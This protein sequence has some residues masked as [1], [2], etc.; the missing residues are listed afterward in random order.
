[1]TT[2]Y[3]AFID[4]NQEGPFELQELVT[5]GVRPST[6]VWCKGMDDWKRADEVEE[7]RS[8]FKRHLEVRKEPAPQVKEPVAAQQEEPA[9]QTPESGNPPEFRFG[10]IPASVEPEPD[11]N[12][13]PRVSMPLAVIAL[14]FFC[15]PTGIAAVIFTYKAQKK[16]DEAMRQGSAELLKKE[17]HE[18]AR[19]AKMWLGLSVAFGIILWTLFFSIV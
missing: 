14:L 4:G 5:A 3:F 13:P 2:K 7:I 11:Y 9:S 19:L 15:L 6:Y 16:W 8:L 18:Y 10:R 12:V 17:A 1:M